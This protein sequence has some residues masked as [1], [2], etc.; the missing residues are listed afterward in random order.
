MLVLLIAYLGVLVHLA[1]Q[2]GEGRRHLAAARPCSTG[3]SPQPVAEG[4]MTP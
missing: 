2:G 1:L 3:R 4:G